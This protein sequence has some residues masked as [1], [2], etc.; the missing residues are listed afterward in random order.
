MCIIGKTIG[1]CACFAIGRTIAKGWAERLINES[2]SESLAQ[3]R[4]SVQGR[5][6]I[7]TILSRFSCER[8]FPN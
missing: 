6:V 1:A 2:N 5:P 8:I 7:T 3:M 4:R